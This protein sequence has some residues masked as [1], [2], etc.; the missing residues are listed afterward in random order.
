MAHDPSYPNSATAQMTAATIPPRKIG[1]STPLSLSSQTRTPPSTIG[2][3][4]AAIT[5]YHVF[6]EPPKWAWKAMA[7]TE[8]SKIAK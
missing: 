2:T 8:A 4:T 5:R 3:D 6:S 7:S 1:R